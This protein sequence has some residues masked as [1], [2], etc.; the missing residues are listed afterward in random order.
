MHDD[1]IV[2]HVLGGDDTADICEDDGDNEE[3]PDV[4]VCPV[5]HAQAMDMFEKCMTWL[6]Y[7][8]EASAYNTSLLISLNDMA[9]KKHLSSLKQMPIT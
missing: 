2:S 1:E 6:Q 5:T 8:P 3:E 4:V 7:Q 9:A